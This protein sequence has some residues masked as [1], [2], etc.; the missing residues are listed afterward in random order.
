MCLSIFLEQK[1]NVGRVIALDEAHK[2]MS[3][4]ASSSTLTDTLLSCIRLQRHL[5]TRVFISTQEPTISPALLDLCSITIVH[6]FTS[7]AWLA[8]LK[9]HLAALSKADDKDDD[10]LVLR[11]SPNV[12]FDRIVKLRV[13]EALVFC[14]SAV[15]GVVLSDNPYG[16]QLNK[17]GT[18]YMKVKMRARITTDGGKSVLATTKLPV[19]PAVFTFNPKPVG[20]EAKNVLANVNKTSTFVPPPADTNFGFLSAGS[21]AKESVLFK[22]PSSTPFAFDLSHLHKPDLA[23]GSKALRPKRPNAK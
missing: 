18:G 1:T 21:K 12:V 17:L 4:T 9:T 11:I 15:I 10:G 5:G 19:K 13:G 14:P 2:Y 23:P 22:T 8:C 16:L 7:P 20:G 6:R 3:E